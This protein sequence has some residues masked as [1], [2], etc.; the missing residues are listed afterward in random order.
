MEGLETR[1]TW[2]KG[3]NFEYQRRMQPKYPNHLV[4]W[5]HASTRQNITKSSISN[6]FLE[7]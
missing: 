4:D 5:K 3:A 7:I 6:H 1:V 2:L